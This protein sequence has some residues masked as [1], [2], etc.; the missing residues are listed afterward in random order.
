MGV[1]MESDAPRFL[2]GQRSLNWRRTYLRSNLLGMSTENNLCMFNSK[3]GLI[4]P[5]QA[6]WDSSDILLYEV[7]LVIVIA[8]HRHHEEVI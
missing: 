7:I 5:S 3:L 2:Y 6:E 4:D 8:D 1:V